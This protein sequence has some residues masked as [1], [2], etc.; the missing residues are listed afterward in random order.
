MAEVFESNNSDDKIKQGRPKHCKFCIRVGNTL[1]M[2]KFLGNSLGTL[3][4]CVFLNRFPDL[5]VYKEDKKMFYQRV[6]DVS[7]QANL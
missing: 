5:L 1:Q 7:L 6:K 4:E 3:P 2:K